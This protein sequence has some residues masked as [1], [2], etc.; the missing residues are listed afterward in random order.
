MSSTPNML[1]KLLNFT[2]D[3]KIQQKKKK[4]KPKTF[5]QEKLENNTKRKQ[6]KECDFNKTTAQHKFML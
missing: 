1:H 6:A 3:S 2:L 5:G 4:I